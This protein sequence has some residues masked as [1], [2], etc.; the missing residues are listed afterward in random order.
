MS[1][2]TYLILLFLTL[3]T[4]AV[5]QPSDSGIAAMEKRRDMLQKELDILSKQAKYTDSIRIRRALLEDRIEHIERI[6][7]AMKKAPDQAHL[8]R[9]FDAELKSLVTEVGNSD[10]EKEL[11]KLY[12]ERTFT[13]KGYAIRK[14]G[15]YMLLYADDP[16]IYEKNSMLYAKMYSDSL[17]LNGQIRLYKSEAIKEHDFSKLY[18]IAADKFKDEPYRMRRGG[19]FSSNFPTASEV[20]EHFR[21]EWAKHEVTIEGIFYYQRAFGQAQLKKWTIV[22]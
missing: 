16:F 10:K 15:S 18:D 19:R 12:H 21:K 13:F 7:G 14:N 11:Q 22:N 17:F 2:L 4:L 6:V 9:F 20:A 1:R 8:L 5:A 3:S